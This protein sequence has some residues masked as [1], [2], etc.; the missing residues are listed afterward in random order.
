MEMK[1]SKIYEKAFGAIYCTQTKT[2]SLLFPI[3]TIYLNN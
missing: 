2:D 1:V 3:Y